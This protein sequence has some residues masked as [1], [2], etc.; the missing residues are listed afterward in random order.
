MNNF[1]KSKN[2]FDNLPEPMTQEEIQEKL[3]NDGFSSAQEWGTF[4]IVD[5]KACSQILSSDRE[6]KREIYKKIKNTEKKEEKLQ[7]YSELG[8]LDFLKEISDMTKEERQLASLE[9][10]KECH[11]VLAEDFNS[12]LQQREEQRKGSI[13]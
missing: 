9:I 3:K 1:D 7:I 13:H 11:Q 6:D 12:L 4:N 8:L 2:P 5:Y 10:M